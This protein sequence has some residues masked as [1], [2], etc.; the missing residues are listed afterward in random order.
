MSW[1]PADSFF[2][3][4]KSLIGLAS[5]FI[6][7][8]DKQAK[9]KLEAQKLQSRTIDSLLGTTTIPWVDAL[10]KVLVALNTLWRPVGGALMTAF[11]M[12]AHWKGI[13]ISTALHATFD[14][15]FPA[16]GLSRHQDKANQEKTR[17]EVERE[18]ARSQRPQTLSDGTPRDLP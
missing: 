6:E 8:P 12:Y 13:D 7:D 5:E 14:G 10:V 2:E 4:G 11:G 15:A 16:W 17:R 1:N 18:K 9:F 3:F